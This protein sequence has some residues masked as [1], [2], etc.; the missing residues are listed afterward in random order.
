MLTPSHPR[1]AALHRTILSQAVTG[2]AV[3]IEH[4]ARMIPLARS[5]DERLELLEDACHER[6][7]LLAMREVAA[8]LGLDVEIAL[9]DAYWGRVR[10]AFGERA[11]AGDIDACYVIQDVVLE[12]YAVTLYRAVLQGV[13]PILAKRIEVVLAD[14]QEHLGHG[15]RALREAHAANPEGA[16]VRVEF[17]N[18][19]VARVLSE[20][21]RPEECEPLCGVCG[22]TGGRCAKPDLELIEVY[23]PKV[24]AGF[25]AHYGRVLREAGF[26]PATVT[27]WLA[28][29]A[30]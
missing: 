27:R 8:E 6:H 25:V 20:W 14:E 11:D 21:I 30:A 3:G 29:L 19:R 12:T 7:H 13:A 4:Y 1:Y 23:M 2:E 17:A 10:G 22:G 5:L 28:R 26:S 9:D 18:E 15:V 16:R 24:Q